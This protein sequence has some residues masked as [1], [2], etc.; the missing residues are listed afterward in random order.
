MAKAISDGQIWLLEVAVNRYK[1]GM[2]TW[3]RPIGFTRLLST[4]GSPEPIGMAAVRGLIRRG[5][6]EEKG[7]IFFATE[8]GVLKL[9]EL[10]K[11]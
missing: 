6:L 9:K 5:Y 4:S 1:S 3:G 2:K 11:E 10:R 8:K 7:G